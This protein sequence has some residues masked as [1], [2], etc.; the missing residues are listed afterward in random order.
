M[1][2]PDLDGILFESRL[3]A[4]RCVAVYDRALDALRSEP[5]IALLQAAQL[6]VE[7]TR[8]GIVLRRKRGFA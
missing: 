3:T 2:V 1:A 4:K 5:P 8:L 6:P 7:I